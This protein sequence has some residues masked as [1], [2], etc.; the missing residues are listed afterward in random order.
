MKKRLLVL[1]A[2]AAILLALAIPA[3]RT[4]IAKPA[5]PPAGPHPQMD[6]ALHSLQEARHHLEKAEPRFAGHRDAA[7]RDV[8]AAIGEIH[9]ALRVNP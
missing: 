4:A 3:I 9:E 6:A 5:A 8:D 7:I 2:S 1:L